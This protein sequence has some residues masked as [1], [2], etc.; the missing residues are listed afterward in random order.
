MH[1]QHIPVA[2]CTCAPG[3][4]CTFLV[5]TQKKKREMSSLRS[6]HSNKSPSP[7]L[8]RSPT[9]S[10]RGSS[11]SLSEDPRLREALVADLEGLLSDES[12]SDL[13]FI[14][15]HGERV[16]AHRLVVLARCDKFRSK[17]SA[18]LNGKYED[19]VTIELGKPC[20]VEGVRAVVKYLYTGK[21]RETHST[22]N[23]IVCDHVN[24]LHV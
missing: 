9:G 23:F 10:K 4:T 1:I 19:T 5:Y 2:T 14:V 24:A 18:W 8:P 17:K 7:A 21:V 13:E 16:K 15:E 3:C 20:A 6:P 12:T 11:S 22:F